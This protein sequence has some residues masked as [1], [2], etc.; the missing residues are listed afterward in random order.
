MAGPGLVVDDRGS[1]SETR[2]LRR[3]AASLARSRTAAGLLQELAII[4]NAK[5]A[6]SSSAASRKDESA[7]FDP[8]RITIQGTLAWANFTEP[9]LRVF[10][11]EKLLPYSPDR[12]APILAHELLGHSLPLLKADKAGLGRSVFARFDGAELYASMVDSAVGLELR[13]ESYEDEASRLMRSTA[14]Y[15]AEIRFWGAG[16]ALALS[17]EEAADPATAYRKRLTMARASLRDLA[18]ERLRWKAREA[19]LKHL[20]DEDGMNRAVLRTARVE[21]RY[22]LDT[23]LPD[24]RERLPQV[25]KAL[26]EELAY[27]R[28]PTGKSD[29]KLLA[30]A[31]G[32][33]FL[34]ELDEKILFLQSRLRDL[35]PDA[36]PPRKEWADWSAVQGIAE[37]DLRRHD[38]LDPKAVQSAF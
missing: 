34:K 6:F 16:Y 38:G 14:A 36:A 3:I 9:Q 2:A 32:H 4:G 5:I 31:A 28:T 8:D 25:I 10:L 15:V 26:E 35:R 11:D 22:R 1:P 7:P 37:E 23:Y 18:G 19:L 27:G 24:R 12:V 29:W 33:P 30:E 21:V 17:R 13:L 20:L